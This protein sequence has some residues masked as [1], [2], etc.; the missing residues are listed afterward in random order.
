MNHVTIQDV[1][2]AAGVSKTTISRFL[3][4][5]YQYMSEETKEKIQAVIKELDYI[6][7]KQARSLKSKQKYLI[8]LI[9][10][11]IG[12]LYSMYLIKAVQDALVDTEYQLVMM[13][14]DNSLEKENHALKELAG[15]DIAGII[16]QPV[17]RVDAPYESLKNFTVPIV[18]ID[19]YLEQ[20]S[21]PSVLTDNFVATRRMG[22][23]IVAAGYKKIV[24]VSEP[25]QGISV[26]LD[27][28]DA[29]KL[30]A[31]ENGL[32]FTLIEAEGGRGLTPEKITAEIDG[33]TAFF[34]A[35]GNALQSLVTVCKKG[36]LGYPEDLGLAGFDDW[37]WAELL[38]PT[39]TSIHQ[40]PTGIG[41][42]ALELLLQKVA[43]G[44][45]NGRLEIA[46]NIFQGDSL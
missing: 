10:A 4:G 15:Q 22:Q 11:D 12:N 38:T 45:F 13:S 34:A 28:H 29:M 31:L 33:P 18:L 5:K 14:T 30:T 43:G 9:V 35:N 1:A 23:L 3:N 41:R 2:K 25:L 26:R 7:S 36:G 40:D 20:V 17:D 37:F 8:G 24:H 19:R 6:P 21:H 39:I 32:G 46:A 42:Q 27:R 44:D 16:L